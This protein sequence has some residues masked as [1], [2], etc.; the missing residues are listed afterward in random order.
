MFFENGVAYVYIMQN[1]TAVRTNVTIGLYTADEIAVTSGLTPGDEVITT[2]SASL[3]D[4]SAV[5]LANEAQETPETAPAS[6]QASPSASGSSSAP[7]QSS[8]AASSQE[9]SAEAEG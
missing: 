8:S 1:G 5:R 9:T 7:S 6:S 2:W 3:R 4:G